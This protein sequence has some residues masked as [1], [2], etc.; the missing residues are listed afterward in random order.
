MLEAAL[1]WKNYSHK[2][3]VLL[4]LEELQMEVDIKKYN[5]ENQPMRFHHIN[6]RFLVLNVSGRART[7]NTHP[8]KDTAHINIHTERVHIKRNTKS[9]CFKWAACSVYSENKHSPHFCFAICVD[10][11]SLSRSPPPAGARCVREPSV[12]A[13][14]R[15]PASHQDSRSFARLSRPG[16]VQR[17]CLQSG[18]G[19][20]PAE[21]Q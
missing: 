4:Y 18:T 19:E 20:G 11:I 1:S 17:V 21:L 7:P 5:M 12:G 15:C 8:S 2:F 16:E 10:V 3:Q 13:Q 14:G 6:K 9:R